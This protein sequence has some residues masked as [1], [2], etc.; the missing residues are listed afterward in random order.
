M[1]YLNLDE[2]DLD[3]YIYYCFFILLVLHKFA[4]LLRLKIYELQTLKQHKIST[5]KHRMFAQ[6]KIEKLYLLLETGHFPAKSES[7]SSEDGS[8]RVRFINIS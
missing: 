2:S 8:D 6:N 7:W 1:S 5:I 4:N 3:R